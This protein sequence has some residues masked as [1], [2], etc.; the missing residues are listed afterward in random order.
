MI[1]RSLFAIVGLLIVAWVVKHGTST[2]VTSS[3]TQVETQVA[4]ANANGSG[5]E[6]IS[7]LGCKGIYSDDK[8]AALFDSNYKGRLTTVTGKIAKAGNGEVELTVLPTTVTY[9]LQVKMKDPHSV[10]D[11]ERG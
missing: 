7:K 3:S 10:Y 5:E 9:D 11:L 2:S 6:M 1:K 8:K 4:L